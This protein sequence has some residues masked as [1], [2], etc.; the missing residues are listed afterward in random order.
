MDSPHF[1]MKCSA[2]LFIKYAQMVLA[3][4]ITDPTRYRRVKT[5]GKPGMSTFQY[6]KAEVPNF[7][8]L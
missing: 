7:V 8:I 5:I 3:Q 4:M 1:F 6:H 2:H